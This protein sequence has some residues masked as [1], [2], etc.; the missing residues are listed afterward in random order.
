MGA[1]CDRCGLNNRTGRKFCADCGSPLPLACRQCDFVN[2]PGERYCG[3]C[4]AALIND[5]TPVSRPGELRQVVVVFADLADYTRLSGRLAPDDVHGLLGRFFDVVDGTVAEH[6]G[7][8]DK[9][10][11]DN[12]MALFGAPI[13]HGNDAE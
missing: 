3:G 10:I 5:S 2:L 12:V 7:T 1:S 11:G 8:I 13:A 6:G 4:A 9:H